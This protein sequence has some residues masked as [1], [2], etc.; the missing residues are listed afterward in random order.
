MYIRIILKDKG[1]IMK[2]NILSSVPTLEEAKLILKE[3]EGLNPGLWIEH[4]KYTG[5]AARLIAENIEGLNSEVAEVLGMLH[6]IGRRVGVYKIRHSIDGYNYAM[7]KGYSLLARVCIT[8]SFPYK[9]INIILDEWDSTEE[10]FNFLK[11]YLEEVEF[12]DYDKLI[13]LCDALAL[14]S[15]FCLLEKRMIDV[16]LRYGVNELTIPKW[17]AT[18]QL[19]DYFEEKMNKSIYNVLPNIAQNTFK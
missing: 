14:P 11:K 2:N 10:N 9:N 8:H 16:A 13:Q 1:E 15:G 3:A 6:D 17:K 7:E 12:D 5:Q 19:K 4:S 18:F